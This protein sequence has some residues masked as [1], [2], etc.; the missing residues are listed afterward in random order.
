MRNLTRFRGN[1]LKELL[2]IFNN[3]RNR[4]QDTLQKNDVSLFKSLFLHHEPQSLNSLR[5]A[6]L[7]VRTLLTGTVLREMILQPLVRVV[8]LPVCVH[9]RAGEELLRAVPTLVQWF[10]G[11]RIGNMFPQSHH[12]GVFFPANVTR[13]FLAVRAMLPDFVDPQGQRIH[14]N[15][16]A[17]VAYVRS[18]RPVPFHMFLQ[19]NLVLE[20]LVAHRALL[21]HLLRR[22]IVCPPVL[23]VHRLAGEPF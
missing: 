4:F 14:R 11:V 9:G 15:V 6:T 7:F 10:S 18:L 21:P 5:T 13:V 2:K 19:A 20:P 1:L 17:N 12:P 23:Q 22:Q 8:L 3:F 16:I